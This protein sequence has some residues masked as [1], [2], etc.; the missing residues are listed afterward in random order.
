MSSPGTPQRSV[1]QTH[2]LHPKDTGS[3]GAQVVLLTGRI[4]HLSVHVK[5][6]PKDNASRRGLL[7]M[8]GHRTSHLKYLARCEPKRHAALV[9]KLGI[10]K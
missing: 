6:H 8:V 7:Q 4:N 9:E 10:R 5:N 2:Q 1:S 3:S